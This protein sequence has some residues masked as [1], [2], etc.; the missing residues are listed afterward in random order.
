[1]RKILYLTLCA[2]ALCVACKQGQQSADADAADQTLQFTTSSHERIL[3]Y[4]VP[5]EEAESMT[6]Y[7]MATLHLV[8]PTVIAGEEPTDLL[9]AVMQTFLGDSVSTTL[10]DA[11]E[12]YLSQPLGAD[13]D[14]FENVTEVD[15]AEADYMHLSDK[16]DFIYVKTLTPHWL[17]LEDNAYEYYAGAAHPMSGRFYLN[18]DLQ[19]RRLLRLDDVVTDRSHLA[20]LLSRLYSEQHVGERP[21]GYSTT[22]DGKGNF[23]IPVTDNFYLTPEGLSFVY[24]PYEIASYAEGIQTLRV[25]F[26][27]L[28]DASIL[29]EPFQR[30]DF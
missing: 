15:S 26:Y 2:A 1:M 30:T 17:V 16:S 24:Q 25:S 22:T 28:M 23:G 6:Y 9:C 19:N 20:V 11:V 10:S 8:L 29:T 3:R 14:T 4:D 5:D 21:Y 13:N 18:Y 7:S 27:E 12:R